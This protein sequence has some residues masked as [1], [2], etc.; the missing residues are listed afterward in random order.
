[1][2]PKLIISGIADY[3]ENTSSPKSPNDSERI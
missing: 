1:M 2:S 3:V